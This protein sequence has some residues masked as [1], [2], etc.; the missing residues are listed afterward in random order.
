VQF[1]SNFHVLIPGRVYRCSQ[2]SPADLTKAVHERGVRTIINLRGSCDP[3]DWYLEEARQTQKLDIAQVDVSFSAGRLP[4]PSE[5]RFLVQ[6]LERAEYPILL[7]CRQGKDRTGLASAIV[8]L[9]EPNS[10]LAT[11]RRQLSLRYGHLALGRTAS[12]D[13]FLDLYDRWLQGEGLSHSSKVFRGWV[14]KEYCPGECRCL[15]EP[16]DV[17]ARVK[18]EEPYALKFRFHNTSRDTWRFRPG[19]NAGVHA[20]LVLWDAEGKAAANSNAGLF[21]TEVAPGGSIDLTLPLPPLH[22]PGRYELMVD[23]T[24]P[25]CFF[26]QAGSEPFERYLQVE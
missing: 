13:H 12:L 23:L 1:G 10:T 24:A 7:H 15:I 19:L 25:Q 16:L 5:V 8:V 11:A 18:A 22:K 20:G 2:P 17:P 4:S 26:Y 6:A 3:L 21:E 14:E 9:L